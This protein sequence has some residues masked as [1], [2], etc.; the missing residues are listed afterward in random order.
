MKTKFKDFLLYSLACIG[1]VSL[2]LSVID[3]PEENAQPLDTY[4]VIASND[5]FVMYNTQTGEFK[6][7]RLTALA[8]GVPIPIYEVQSF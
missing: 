6:P 2:L 3:K 8:A 7:L 1:A 4:H 5:V